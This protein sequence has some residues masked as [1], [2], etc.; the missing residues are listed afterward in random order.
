VALGCTVDNA[1]LVEA[2]AALIAPEYDRLEP[3]QA[4][5]LSISALEM[6]IR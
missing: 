3:P 4:F 2:E 5:A 1:G 6:T